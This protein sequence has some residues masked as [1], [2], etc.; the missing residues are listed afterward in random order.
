MHGIDLENPTP[1]HPLPRG[2]TVRVKPCCPVG[3]S[4]RARAG[5]CVQAGVRV[6]VRVCV[7]VRACARVC[8]RA[9]MCA[10]VRAR[11]G[12]W[13]HGCVG[14][15]ST[16]ALTTDALCLLPRGCTKSSLLALDTPSV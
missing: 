9:R 14:V 4:M 10:G 2:S 7:R 16:A 11:A 13:V 1:P 6:C 15:C 8:V 12:A 3:R 5:T